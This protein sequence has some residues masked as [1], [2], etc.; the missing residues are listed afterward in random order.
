M[1]QFYRARH[2]LLEEIED[3]HEILERLNS[4]ES[5]EVLAKDYSECPSAEKGGMLGTFSSGS[6]VAEFER[7]LYQMK[8]GEVSGPVQ[9][10]FGFHIIEK[11][12]V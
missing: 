5:F 11:L 10:K 7:A 12:K 4:G 2:I 1:P 3:A 8:E 9:T 6:M